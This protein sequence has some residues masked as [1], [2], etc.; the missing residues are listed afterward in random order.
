MTER[1]KGTFE[2]VGAGAG[3]LAGRVADTGVDLMGSMIRTVARSVGGWWSD[4]RPDDA[5]RS[6]DERAENSCRTHFE[7]ARRSRSSYDSVRP[8][9]QFGH[10]AGQNPDY[11]GRSF[12]EVES[13]L[14][15]A[16]SD[17]QRT[18]YGEWESVRDY[19]SGGYS[20]R[21]PS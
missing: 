20:A 15:N 6:F 9:Y 12:E 18:R 10:L 7:S 13:D 11:Q 21:N 5:A 16:W 19:V 1:D 4:R 14:R 17:D 2:K 8:L 3:G